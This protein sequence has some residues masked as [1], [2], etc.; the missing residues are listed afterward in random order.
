MHLFLKF[1]LEGSNP[2]KLNDFLN[3]FIELYLA[4]DLDEKNKITQI[5]YNLLINN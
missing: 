5:L 4:K 3:K 1:L 2:E